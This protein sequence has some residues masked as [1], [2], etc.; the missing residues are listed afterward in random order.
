MKGNVK[1]AGLLASLCFVLAVGLAV[2]A[3]AQSTLLYEIVENLDPGPLAVGHRISN[4]TAQG[5]APADSPF[6]PLPVPC[7]ITAFGTDDIDFAAVF[8]EAPYIGTVWANVAAVTNPEFDNAVDA[9]EFVVFTGQIVGR[10]TLFS[11]EGAPVVADLKGKKAVLGT[12]FPLIFVEG[13][14]HA[15]AGPTVRTQPGA[16]VPELDSGGQPFHA[17]FRL[18]FKVGKNG[19]RQKPERGKNAYYLSDDGTKLI[20]VDKQNEFLFGFPLLRGEVF[21]PTP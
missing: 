13:Q 7:T 20:K 19:E 8:G 12:S 10:L 9:A 4:W 17:T 6:C 16:D 21:F 5:T 1:S 15:D 14:F 2:P 18:P 3:A 11:P